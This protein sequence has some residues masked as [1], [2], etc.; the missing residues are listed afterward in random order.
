MSV[1][2]IQKPKPVERL[3]DYRQPQAGVRLTALRHDSCRFIVA[4]DDAPI[5]CGDKKSR[6][7]YCAEHYSLCYV[8]VKKAMAAKIA[9]L[10][11]LA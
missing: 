11:K 8:P 7:S 4:E 6:G 3:F 10:A 1:A 2:T 5:Y 9:R